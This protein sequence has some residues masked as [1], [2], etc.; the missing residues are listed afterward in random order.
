MIFPIIFASIL[1]FLICAGFLGFVIGIF[2]ALK[3]RVLKPFEGS[4][5]FDRRTNTVV[6][7]QASSKLLWNKIVKAPENA[8]V[9]IDTWEMHVEKPR[10]NSFTFQTF[11]VSLA[12]LE[13]LPGGADGPDSAR[14][15]CYQQWGTNRGEFNTVEGPP[16]S[17]NSELLMHC[18]SIEFAAQYADQ[19]AWGL[20]LQVI[21]STTVASQPNSN[22]D[23][24]AAEIVD[25]LQPMAAKTSKPWYMVVRKEKEG[26][27]VG[28]PV[29]Q[30]LHLLV[31]VVFG[32]LIAGM[33]AMESSWSS[34]AIISSI[35]FLI[36]V[37]IWT[38]KKW[39]R[40]TPQGF[41]IAASRVLPQPG[42]ELVSFSTVHTVTVLPG[43]KHMN[44]FF[45][46]R[47]RT[48]EFSITTPIGGGKYLVQ[49]FLEMASKASTQSE[50]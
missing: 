9:V 37:S 34:L 4:L 32:L 49:S 50:P 6:R 30:S 28:V 2:V 1:G 29:D 33:I 31:V 23:G 42:V 46:I 25:S 7:R 44:E 15:A 45:Y 8:V 10:G 17:E 41:S 12:P 24:L 38:K 48:A 3:K 40:L 39:L 20:D 21:D 16:I 14:R 22:D 13:A 5:E 35:A 18:R 43:V 11:R 19:I 47:T 26:L 36:V 27:F